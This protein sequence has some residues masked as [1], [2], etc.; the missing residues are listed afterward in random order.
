MDTNNNQPN[1]NNQSNLEN[2]QTNGNPTNNT[3]VES[4]IVD[5]VPPTAVNQTNVMSATTLNDSNGISGTIPNIP[6]QNGN[7]NEQPTMPNGNVP[8]VTSNDNFNAVPTPP[9]FPKEEKPKKK[10]NKTLIILLL[11]IIVLLIGFGLYYFLVLAKNNTPTVTN[12]I[13]PKVVNIELGEDIPLDI[14]TYADISGYDALSCSV[15]TQEID[16][17]TINRYNFTVTCGTDTKNG[18]AIVDD[19]VAPEVVLND[20]E[21][22]VGTTPVVEDFVDYCID[23]SAC[24]YS[25]NTDLATLINSPGEYDVEIEV[26]DSRE[27]SKIVVAKLI[28]GESVASSYITCKSSIVD[29]DEI[30]G[31]NQVVY[32]IGI[33]ANNKF[34]NATRVDNFT[35]ENVA[36][37]KTQVNNYNDNTGINGII[38]KT[39]FDNVNKTIII[40]NSKTFEELVIENGNTGTISDDAYVLRAYL[41]FNG[42]TCE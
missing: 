13:M 42:F 11:V 27:N 8:P 1:L 34:Y 36:D 24:S 9:V 33:D 26:A 12:M 25:L 40:K 4:L 38:G 10:Q 5:D 30:Y 39:Y 23:A 32:K 22:L 31:T 15:N 35:F 14:N 7:V 3:P 20:L 2:N 37:Y 21:V 41:T 17:K 19:T 28:V 18:V 16:N 29:I 6:N